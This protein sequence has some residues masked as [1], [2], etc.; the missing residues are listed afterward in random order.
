MVIGGICLGSIVLFGTFPQISKIR[1]TLAHIGIYLIIFV[2]SCKILW[3]SQDAVV[4]KRWVVVLLFLT[5]TDLTIS[6]SHHIDILREDPFANKTLAGPSGPFH[7]RIPYPMFAERNMIIPDDT[8]FHPASSEAEHMFPEEYVGIYHHP[9]W[10]IWWGIKEWL[11]LATH[12]EGQKF[13]PN[14]NAE[15]IRMKKYPDFQFFT[16]GYFVPFEMLK[17]IGGGSFFYQYCSPLFSS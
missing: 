13:L 14:W 1:H 5:F 2:I 15:R 17:N 10:Q 4:K 7:G 6:A 9:S 3:I 8:S 12:S 16:N 11:V